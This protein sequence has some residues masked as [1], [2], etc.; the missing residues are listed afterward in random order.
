MTVLS[1]SDVKS[2]LDFVY[3]AASVTGP[4]PFPAELLERLGRLL[5]ADA[6]VGYH[7]VIVGSPCRAL[8]SV[9]IPADATPRDVQ[10]AGKHFKHQDP[11]R[12]GVGTREARPLKCS[13][14]LTRRER[15][16]LDFYWYVWKPLGIDDSIK[17]WLP[18]PSGRARLI[19]IERSRRDFTERDRLFLAFLRPSLIRV[20]AAAY[21]RRRGTSMLTSR[22]WEILGLIAE[23][24]TSRE[25]AS[26][27][28][29]SPHTVR[30]HVE[31]VLEKLDVSTRSAAVVRAFSARRDP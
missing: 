1:E 2:A 24:K 7:D 26:I 10:E 29:V 23:G 30:K 13:D 20:Q 6:L 12:H 28:V 8:E 19:F 17:V 22:E 4:D 14:F 11:L 31:H 5:D 3:D 16:K 18:A 15:R 9:E 27:L 21:A 25:I